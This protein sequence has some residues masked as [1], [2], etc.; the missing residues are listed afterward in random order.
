[1]V[2]L[3]FYRSGIA[4]FCVGAS[5]L[6]FGDRIGALLEAAEAL[7][8]LFHYGLFGLCCLPVWHYS[9]CVYNYRLG[10]A[11]GEGD[12]RPGVALQVAQRLLTTVIVWRAGLPRDDLSDSTSVMWVKAMR[13]GA[14]SLERCFCGNSLVYS[15]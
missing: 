9:R 6:D 15:V 2:W 8:V 14:A 1:M 3:D 12:L 4:V 11:F 13:V 5:A 10:A 7:H